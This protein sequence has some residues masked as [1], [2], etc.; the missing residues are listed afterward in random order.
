MLHPCSSTFFKCLSF[1]Q[2]LSSRIHKQFTFTHPDTP[3]RYSPGIP[4]ENHGTP[5]EHSSPLAR[6]MSA[7][8]CGSLWNNSVSSWTR[9]PMTTSPDRPPLPPV[10]SEAPRRGLH[11]KTKSPKSRLR[12]KMCSGVILTAKLVWK[13]GLMPLTAP[14]RLYFSLMES[15]PDPRKLTRGDT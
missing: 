2:P 6:C 14:C 10:S 13:C 3:A 8:G 15:M 1:V 9:S 11:A 12:Q 4:R 5:R 7:D